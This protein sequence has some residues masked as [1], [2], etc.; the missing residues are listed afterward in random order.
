MA[1]SCTVEEIL[2]VLARVIKPYTPQFFLTTCSH[3]FLY[4]HYLPR[5]R[6]L[7]L[8]KHYTKDAW[9]PGDKCLKY[10]TQANV[11]TFFLSR[12]HLNHLLQRQCAAHKTQTWQQNFCKHCCCC[13]CCHLVY[14][15]SSACHLI[16]SKFLNKLPPI[17][18][19]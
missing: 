14:Q 7:K 3:L 17:F 13:C 16:I 10:K 19:L 9:F 11:L 12:V 5:Q 2:C 6:L 4:Q 15:N 1:L 8:V 18:L